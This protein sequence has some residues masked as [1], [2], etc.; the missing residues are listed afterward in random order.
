MFT[1]PAADNA[2]EAKS[3]EDKALAVESE[4]TELLKNLLE[5]QNKQ[6]RYSRIMG[7]ALT[8][9]VVILLV[10]CLILVPEV[11]NTLGKVN[12]LIDQADA[13]IAEVDTQLANLDTTF[14]S[15]NEMSGEITTAAD[16]INGLVDDNAEV[17]T[18]A[19][20]KLNAIDFD[21]L[22]QSISD[23]QSV[24]EPMAN[25]MNKFR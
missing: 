12:N 18:E 16:G 23:L 20:G 13:T 1:A 2:E 25:F 10:V 5:R 6:L 19:M 21:G 8:V 7:I 9:M 24:V 17:L 22:N 11:V 3:F 4:E 15:L 14:D